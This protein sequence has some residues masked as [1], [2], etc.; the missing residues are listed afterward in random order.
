MTER[1]WLRGLAWLSLLGPLFFVTYNFANRVASE[2]ADVGTVLF[3]WEPL[4]PFVAWTVV[5]YWSSDVL[6][7]LS[8]ATCRDRAECD[9][10]GLRLLAIQLFSVACFLA[11]PLRLVLERPAV[12]GIPGQMFAALGQFD[13]AFNEAPSLHVALA[14][15]LWARFRAVTAGVWRGLLAVW[16]VL[17]AISPLTTYQHHFIDI[18]TGAWAGVLTL[19]L[20][21]ERR[22]APARIR[23]AGFY[24]GGA[25]ICTAL[26]FWVQG[27]AWALLWP[28]FA[29]SMVAAAYWTGDAAWLR[30]RLLVAPYAA[31][32]WINSRLWTRGQAPKNHLAGP[33]WIGR[34]PWFGERDGMRSVVTLAP[35]LHLRGDESVAMLDLA[36]PTCQQLDEAVS[37]IRR[38]ALKGPALVCCALGYS[39]SAIASAAWLIAEGHAR[40]AV[41]AVEQVRR[42]RPQVVLRPEFLM[43]LDE[44]AQARYE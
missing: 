6:Y 20:V 44:W 25:V 9:R 38:V 2:R 10:H 43:R 15:I 3:S 17:V 18:V 5:P 35:E 11:F 27:A 39:R 26:A 31:G 19:A 40:G 42:A 14:V 41:D 29:L 1:P 16:F 21:P 7:A 33:I 23:L 22:V 37:A 36:P 32:A 8:F 4:L 12:D 30:A 13:L 28:G 34:A 24:L